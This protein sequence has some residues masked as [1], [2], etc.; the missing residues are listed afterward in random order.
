MLNFA[1]KTEYMITQKDMKMKKWLSIM[2]L[3]LVC[4]P[5]SGQDLAQTEESD[6]IYCVIFMTSSSVNLPEKTITVTSSP[7]STSMTTADC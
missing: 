4:L 3:A 1:A 5:G 7:S 6:F 2:L